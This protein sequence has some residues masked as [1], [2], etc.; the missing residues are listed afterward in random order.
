MRFDVLSRI[1]IEVV[2]RRS[3]VS[4]KRLSEE[5]RRVTGTWI[6]W[7]SW[8]AWLMALNERLAAFGLPGITVV[9][10]NAKTGMAG[11]GIWACS[12]NVPPRPATE[13]GERAEQNRLRDLVYG[14]IWP[15]EL[16][17]VVG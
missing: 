13:A 10:I 16:P 6:H 17:D 12:P 5:Y 9:V 8:G 7:R 4:Y 15:D 1:L 2:R 11:S 14:T 3:K